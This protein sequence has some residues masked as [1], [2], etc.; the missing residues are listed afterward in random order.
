[1]KS[2]EVASELGW[3]ASKQ[4]RLEQAESANLDP[5]HLSVL[6]KLLD[7]PERFFVKPPP[8]PLSAEDLLF[9]APAATPKREKSYLAEFARVT[10]EVLDWLDDYHRLPPVKVP[11][12]AAE[13]PVREAASAV[14]SSL[15]L[16]D[17]QPIDHL[18]HRAERAGVPIIMRGVP[19]RLALHRDGEESTDVSTERHLGYSARVGAH[20]ER[21]V[22]I[23]RANSSWERIRWTVAHELG[24]LALHGG[25]LP[26]DSEEQAN[27]FASELLAPASVVRQELPVHVTLASLT[28]MKL[29]WGISLGALTIHL[30]RNGLITEERFETLRRQ[31]YTRMNPT[32]GRTW[33]RDEPGWNE[34]EVERP[35]LLN[36]WLERCVG[37]TSPN[38]VSQISGI[39]PTDLLASMIS[40]QR[41]KAPPSNV[42]PIIR[43]QAG[44]Q[45]VSLESWRLRQA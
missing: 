27:L 33:G 14:R 38:A 17:D 4:T 25:K 7:F 21:P 34:K 31:L 12:L 8:S 39:W 28:P 20:G 9:R 45:V 41:E 22:T 35:G 16:S 2:A 15:S 19:S 6:A 1:M 26:I 30:R 44:G 42:R 18:I 29:R 3:P 43:K 40:G 37:F 5:R 24:H 11:T 36:A 10:G 32:T 23:L 13:T